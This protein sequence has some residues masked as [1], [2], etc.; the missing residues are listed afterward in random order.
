MAIAEAAELGTCREP[1]NVDI[2]TSSPSPHTTMPPRRSNP[3]KVSSMAPPA[4]SPPVAS[5]VHKRGPS[6]ADDNQQTKAKTKKLR[7][8]DESEYEEEGKGQ[9]SGKKKEKKE[10]KKKTAKTR[11]EVP[12][13][14]IGCHSPFFNP[15]AEKRAPGKPLRLLPSRLLLH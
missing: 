8:D 9:G 2:A 11:Y 14:T 4:H 5:R 6:N 7:A 15:P 3:P 10:K 13:C 1:P 12:I